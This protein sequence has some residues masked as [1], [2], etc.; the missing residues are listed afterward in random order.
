MKTL[1]L[2]LLAFTIVIVPLSAEQEPEVDMDQL[3]VDLV[4]SGDRMASIFCLFI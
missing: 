1:S 4:G 3:L 2:A